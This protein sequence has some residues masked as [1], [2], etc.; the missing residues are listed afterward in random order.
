M[1]VDYQLFKIYRIDVPQ[2]EIYVGSTT[3]RYLSQRRGGHVADSK[4]PERS[5]MLLYETINISNTKWLGIQVELVESYPCNTVD[6]LRQ[7]E[8]YWIRLLKP[9]F[10]HDMPG[11]TCREWKKEN[12]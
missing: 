4:K 6:E 3:K 1:V 2:C 5:N 12:K 8:A 9:E 7:R 11:R 10:N